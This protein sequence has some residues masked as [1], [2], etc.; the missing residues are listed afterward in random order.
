ML[1]TTPTETPVSAP[2]PTFTD[3]LRNPRLLAEKRSRLLEL[4]P[5]RATQLKIDARLRL[6]SAQADALVRVQDLRSNTAR[7]LHTLATRV[8]PTS[9]GSC[10]CDAVAEA[11]KPVETPNSKA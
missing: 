11:P 3:L 5:A 7:A 10:G 1:E 8:E 6:V 4:A 9:A 2:P